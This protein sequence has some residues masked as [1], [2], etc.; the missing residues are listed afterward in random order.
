[1]RHEGYDVSA[2]R[3]A[4]DRSFLRILMRAQVVV[5][6]HWLFLLNTATAIFL[7]LALLTPVFFSVGWTAPAAA[8]FE[9]YHIACHQ[10]PERSF[11]IAGQQVA[12]CQRDVGTYA[13]IL[14]GGIAF[15]FARGWMRP[16]R[17]RYYPLFLAPMALDAGTQLF[18]WRE[19]TWEL[20]LLT[21]VLF[22]LGTVWL[23]F[24]FIEETMVLVRT[25]AMAWLLRDRDSRK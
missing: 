19:S 14:A 12:V 7:G 23:L 1:M 15:V 16:L 10:L 18:G 17:W 3:Q 11:F 21:G 4:F 24:P 20:R 6:R 22:G 13:A 2:G 25:D 9:S 8:L 5:A